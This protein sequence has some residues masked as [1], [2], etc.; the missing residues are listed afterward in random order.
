[1]DRLPAEIIIRIVDHFEMAEDRL[2]IAAVSQ[3]LRHSVSRS[4]LARD[5]RSKS[6]FFAILSN[7]GLLFDMAVTRVMEQGIHGLAVTWQYDWS[8]YGDGGRGLDPFEFAVPESLPILDDYSA[9]QVAV[10][11]G[12]NDLVR[13]LLRRGADTRYT[14]ACWGCMDGADEHQ[15]SYLPL[16]TPTRTALHMAICYGN[17]EAALEL[18][19]SGA[20]LVVSG[21]DAHPVSDTYRVGN[22]AAPHAGNEQNVTILHDLSHGYVSGATP[23]QIAGLA[24]LQQ[25]P[26]DIDVATS[27]QEAPVARA[28]RTGHFTLANWLL[29]N[30]ASTTATT[31]YR[32]TETLLL[33]ALHA[34]VD[35][36]RV[37]VDQDTDAGVEYHNGLVADFNELPGL[38]STLISLGVDVNA[39]GPDSMTA[40]HL[41]AMLGGDNSH[42]T[43][44]GSIADRLLL[45]G[46]DPSRTTSSGETALD[47]AKRL[48]SPRRG[49][50]EMSS[51]APR[52]PGPLGVGH[53]PF[54]FLG[55]LRRAIQP[56]IQ[57]FGGRF[58]VDN[59]NNR[60]FLICMFRHS[61]GVSVRQGRG[62]RWLAEPHRRYGTLLQ[63]RSTRGVDGRDNRCTLP[64]SAVTEMCWSRTGP[65][66][67]V[68]SL[69][70]GIA[71]RRGMGFSPDL[72]GVE[73][74]AGFGAAALT[75]RQ[76]LES[77]VSWATSHVPI[78]SVV[79]QSTLQRQWVRTSG[80]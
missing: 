13:E 29:A 10:V 38:V 44:G 12:R 73:F 60:F 43:G 50:S 17:G 51:I 52:A 59:H 80:R 78:V 54:E 26:R 33:L 69:S 70:S 64:V 37:P 71:R 72:V 47:M 46:A 11:L 41:A 15:T 27:W 2:R 4:F 55:V 62:L 65:P 36:W 58:A 35:V 8:P 7:S 32:P 42:N 75:G 28:C 57:G 74:T 40:L 61:S 24:L 66:R 9:L 56:L 14:T 22:W 76:H 48:H 16:T 21:P 3:T 77:F 63:V 67:A 20:P 53:V 34:A 30:G 6:L 1:M 31:P 39:A 45:A 25:Q 49:Q 23:A 5:V 79:T 68:F 19:R 18:L